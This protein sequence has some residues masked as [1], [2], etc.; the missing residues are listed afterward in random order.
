[1]NRKAF[2][3]ISICLSVGVSFVA[4]ELLVRATTGDKFTSR[5]G[6]YVPGGELGWVPNANLDHEFFGGDY[7]IHIR[8]DASGF[9]LGKLGQVDFA[10]KLVLLA[11]DSFTFGWGASTTETFA[12]FLDEFVADGSSGAARV[13]NLGVGGYGSLQSAFRVGRLLDEHPDAKVEA[14]L[15]TH[16]HNDM[17]DN[18][19]NIGFQIGSVVPEEIERR[20]ASSSNLV[21]MLRYMRQVSADQ[22]EDDGKAADQLGQ[23]VLWALSRVWVKKLPEVITIGGATINR[24]DI[25]DEDGDVKATTERES[26][27]EVQAELLAESVDMLHRSLEGRNAVVFHALILTAPDWYVRAIEEI[28]LAAERHGSRVVFLGRVPDGHNGPIWNTHGGGHYLPE[29]NEFWARTMYSVLEREL[30]SLSAG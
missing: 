21:N 8:T 28:V 23:D 11:G 22:G 19:R 12:S 13:V 6:F 4:A 30:P 18:V 7:S 27:S 14:V 3:A 1:M 20:N 17:T 26:L 5:P 10:G 24:D 15:M 16:C 2:I 9:R 29:V 25:T